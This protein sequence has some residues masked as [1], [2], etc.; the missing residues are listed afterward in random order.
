MATTKNSKNTRRFIHIPPMAFNMSLAEHGKEANCLGYAFGKERIITLPY[1]GLSIAQAFKAMAIKNHISVTQVKSMSDIKD[2]KAF[3]VYGFYK[4][5][6]D[7]PNF[8]VVYVTESGLGFH[9][10]NDS[11]AQYVIINEQNGGIPGYEDGPS[12]IF[13]INE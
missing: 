9:K 2:R 1:K 8:H 11:L 10:P 5:S 6:K 12:A 3:L 7:A 4:M 13:V